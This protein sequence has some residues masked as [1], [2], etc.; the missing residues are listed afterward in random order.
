MNCL[1][2]AALLAAAGA[3]AMQLELEHAFCD[4]PTGAAY[5]P[6]LSAKARC[7]GAGCPA[8]DGRRVTLQG[9]RWASVCGRPLWVEETSGWLL[10]Y[11]DAQRQH[12]ARP[13][14]T[15]LATTNDGEPGY[16]RGGAS[17]GR[18]VYDAE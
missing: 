16:L 6:P 8:L 10:F 13:T 18:V 14:A 4:M 5:E 15:E 17:C 1:L 2:L 3:A 7:K 12:P 9:A 11:E